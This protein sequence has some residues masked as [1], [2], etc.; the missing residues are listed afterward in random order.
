[1]SLLSKL[2]VSPLQ[3]QDP[4]KDGSKIINLNLDGSGDPLRLSELGE[5]DYSNSIKVRDNEYVT[6][7]L[8]NDYSVLTIYSMND[9][10][11]NKT[12]NIKLP[13]Q[14]TNKQHTSIVFVKDEAFNVEFILRNSIYLKISIPIDFI[15]N[16]SSE[17][18]ED[19]FYVLQPYDF[20]VR[21]PHMLH[22]VSD[23][24]SV[25][26]LEDGGLVGLTSHGETDLEP[27]LFNDNS[28]LQSITR[29]FSKSKHS[30]NSKVVSC[31]NYQSNFL[32]VLT[33]D[34]I[35]KI[36]DLKKLIL[37]NEYN[38]FDVNNSDFIAGGLF[39][40]CGN[41]LHLFNNLLTIYLPFTNGLFQVGT[42]DVDSS[43]KLTFQSKIVI[44]SNLPAS[45]LWS[46]TDMRMI[47]PLDLN[48]PETFLNIIVL[49]KSGT[50]SK[51]QILNILNESVDSYE[52]ID[53]SNK[54]LEETRIES[55]IESSDFSKTLF[56]LTSRYP[57]AIVDR[58][59][60]VLEENGISIPLQEALDE[61]YLANLETLLRD[62]K[63]GC[64]EASS[65]TLYNDEIIV[66]NCLQKYNYSIYK[67]N[68][69]LEKTYF[70]INDDSL[71][72]DL[73]RY[74][75]T[76]WGFSSTVPDHVL[77]NI[78]H[79]FVG[80]ITK[81][82]P[83]TL[84]PNE[85]LTNIYKTS[86]ESQLEITNINTLF[87]EL[88][89]FDV[90]S[91]LNTLI[92][93]NLQV[94][95]NSANTYVDAIKS[96]SFS[97][98][99]TMKCLKN[100]ITVQNN[101]VLR[102]LLTFTLLDFDYSVFEKQLNALLDLHY[103]Q[104]LF[105]SLYDLDKS[106]LSNELFKQT[107][108]FGQGIKLYSYSDLTTFLQYATFKFYEIDINS[109]TYFQRYFNDMVVIDKGTNI[110][111]KTELLEYIGWPYFIRDNKSNEFLMA[112]L[113]FSCGK[114]GQS[115]EFFK[116]HDYVES[117]ADSLP[118]FFI[119][120]TKE[121]NENSWK[122]LI[123]SFQSNYN[124]TLYYYELSLLFSKEGQHEYALSSIKKSLEY[125]MKDVEIEVP[126]DF[127]VKQLTQ[128]LNMLIHFNMF[129]EALDVLRFSHVV[130]S[131][132]IRRDYFKLLLN[133]NDID[134]N[135]F[136]TLLNLCYTHEGQDMYLNP[137]DFDIIDGILVQKL[138]AFSWPTYKRLYS[139]RML[140]KNER[141][142]A[143][144]VYDYSVQVHDNT[145]ELKKCY[146]IIINILSSF[147]KENDQWILYNGEIIT[148]HSLEN[149][150]EKL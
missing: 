148:L 61:E 62:I 131:N 144:V 6:Y 69:S 45:S 99:I 48:L 120:L 13:V 76:V 115:Y 73:S 111:E 108:K 20:S 39:D 136:A 66:I 42:L 22:R 104:V 24:F 133:K 4:S 17:L 97:N 2:D 3:F 12:I 51:L 68:C 77:K 88:S 135:F 14:S 96:E 15:I 126:R 79:Q 50:M 40:S 123:L 56:K 84:T 102:I 92:D 100:L 49:W 9:A 10:L 150:I 116:L 78:S 85:K 141:K 34:C 54:D 55:D 129:R 134:G 89:S 72:D 142:A 124:H 28:Y 114:F 107:T 75:R 23:N 105:I 1:M 117:I 149:R 140:N 90:I 143:E 121:N 18:N 130:L 93:N 7:H 59:I 70:D 127:K 94:F 74:L 8:S 31:S 44:P 125:Q 25:V 41:Y 5:S 147:E 33:E 65:L 58:A 80:I 81:S 71:N 132:D 91:I 110:I 19:W 145:S 16:N 113:L 86:L 82:I 26:F 32:I 138:R 52:W 118:P 119:E 122:P 128:Y 95:N 109:N 46:L 60:K 57:K 29:L 146:L 83:S 21:K 67:I 103:K 37:I 139:Y 11:Q 101:F 43:D 137:I 47:N 87:R 36:W 112:I 27:I 64:D 98:I 63:G 30:K 106:K 38:L 35:L 53:A